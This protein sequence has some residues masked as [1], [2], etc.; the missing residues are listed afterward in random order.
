[1]VQ[2]TPS[3]ERQFRAVERIERLLEIVSSALDGAGIPDAVI[4]GNAAATWVATRD[5]VAVRATKDLDVLLRRNDI[6]RVE[7]V[8]APLGFI[9]ADVKAPPVFMEASDPLPNQGIHVIVSNE[10]V[11]AHSHFAAPDVQA[12]L[13]SRSGDMVVELLPLVIMKLNAFRRHDQVYLEDLF[14]VGLIDAKLAAQVPSVLLGR[15]RHVRDTMEW[16]TEP[17]KF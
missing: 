17:P 16:F 4:E 3:I 9:S 8:L 14:R 1:M 7:G 12:A 2:P 11:R 13:R 10:K 6:E 5:A 15:L